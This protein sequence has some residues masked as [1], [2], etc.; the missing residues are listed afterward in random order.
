MASVIINSLFCLAQTMDFFLFLPLEK[1]FSTV[2]ASCNLR[3]QI[4]NE[5]PLSVYGLYPL[6]F[7][8]F[9]SR[10]VMDYIFTG[11]FA[12]FFQKPQTS[13]RTQPGNFSC[14]FADLCLYLFRL[15][16]HF[17]F[18]LF[19]FKGNSRIRLLLDDQRFFLFLDGI[20]GRNTA[21]DILCDRNQSGGDILYLYFHISICSFHGICSFAFAGFLHP[22][23]RRLL[24]SMSFLRHFLYYFHYFFSSRGGFPTCFL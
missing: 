22:S 2:S 6:D 8:R 13:I 16:G 9:S 11:Q 15:Y 12:A 1:D 14:F 19:H 17:V 5:V 4:L 7:R 21:D 24:L 20:S 3:F 18:L 23:I 10:R